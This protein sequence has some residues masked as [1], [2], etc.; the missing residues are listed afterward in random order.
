MSESFL[1]ET[2]DLTSDISL[3]LTGRR[4]ARRPWEV[5]VW[6]A[7]RRTSVKY[8]TSRLVGRPNKVFPSFLHT[9]SLFMFIRLLFFF[10]DVEVVARR[11]ESPS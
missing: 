4:S 7:K 8:K 9:D 1:S 6:L 5:R 11:C 10:T 3:L 2:L